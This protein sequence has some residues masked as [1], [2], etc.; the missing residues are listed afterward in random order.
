MDWTPVVF[1]QGG[2]AF[3]FPLWV[4]DALSFPHFF[5]FLFVS[6]RARALLQSAWPPLLLPP[7]PSWRH[8]SPWLALWPGCRRAVSVKPIIH[9]PPPRPPLAIIIL[10]CVPNSQHALLSLSLSF[11]LSRHSQVSRSSPPALCNYVTNWNK[12]FIPRSRL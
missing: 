4:T 6:F 3:L 10:V 7:C 12:V 1:S 8:R 11:F 5:F 9:S 2:A